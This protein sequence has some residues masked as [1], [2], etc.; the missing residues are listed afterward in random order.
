MLKRF[1][2]DDPV[3]ERAG[4]GAVGLVDHGNDVVAAVELA[5]GLAELE[6]GGD[7]DLAGVLLEQPLQLLIV[8]PPRVMA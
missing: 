8:A 7:D 4:E 1:Y 3:A 5:V 2:H 6:D